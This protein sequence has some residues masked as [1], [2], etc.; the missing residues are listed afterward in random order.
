MNTGRIRIVTQ[1]R[2]ESGKSATETFR[3]LNNAYGRSSLVLLSCYR[4]SRPEVVCW[5]VQRR[6][7]ANAKK[8]DVN[9]VGCFGLTSKRWPQDSG[10]VNRHSE[11]GR[12]TYFQKKFRKRENLRGKTTVTCFS[13][14][15]GIVVDFVTK[16]NTCLSVSRLKNEENSP[17]ISPS[18]VSQHLTDER[19]KIPCRE[20]RK[21]TKSGRRSLF[22]LH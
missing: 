12:S 18:G 7:R 1:F 11:K 3:M 17:R 15:D 16:K 5:D 20:K 8:T 2:N 4:L 22:L 13:R 6:G 9:N 21:H 14:S 10:R 19:C